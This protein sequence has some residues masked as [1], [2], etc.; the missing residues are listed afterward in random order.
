MQMPARKPIKRRYLLL[1][2]VSCALMAAPVW[3]IPGFRSLPVASPEQQTYLRSR[4]MAVALVREAL[5]RLNPRDA[6]SG[7][8]VIW[9]LQQAHFLVSSDARSGQ[10]CSARQYSL[11][12]NA[13]YRNQIFICYEVR[14]HA[15]AADQDALE[16]IAQ[17]F[18]HEAV[19]L[20]GEMDEC[21]ATRFE[22]RVM[23]RTIG[24]QSQGSQIRY[25]PQ[26]RDRR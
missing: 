10:V 24:V 14:P 21:I 5:P 16:R 7:M 13:Y 12:V 3:A 19:H 20:T 18:I 25:G 26:C 4:A 17:G 2:M 9:A 22:R 23:D 11:F 8:R 1:P 15:R 6:R